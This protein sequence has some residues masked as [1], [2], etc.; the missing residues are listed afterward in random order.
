MS[1]KENTRFIALFK[2]QIWC[3][4]YVTRAIQMWDVECES[5]ADS[6]TQKQ[7]LETSHENNKIHALR[8]ETRKRFSPFMICRSTRQNVDLL[9]DESRDEVTDG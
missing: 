9:R 2:T 7:S 1:E 8:R 5:Q 4:V 3:C 6:S